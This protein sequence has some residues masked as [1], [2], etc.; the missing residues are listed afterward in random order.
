MAA[1]RTS[2]PGRSNQLASSS[3]GPHR[4][5]PFDLAEHR[6]VGLDAGALVGRRFAVEVRARKK[7]EVVVHGSGCDFVSCIG[8]SPGVPR[9]PSWSASSERPRAILDLTVP[10][11]TPSSLGDLVVVE[12]G[13]VAEHDRGPEVVGQAGDRGVERH[14]IRHR[15]DAALGQAIG[16]LR[17]LAVVAHDVQHRAPAPAAE[18][19]EGG[20]AGDPV[21]PC[22]ER[23][24]AVERA[25]AP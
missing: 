15:V 9:F 4:A 16:G 18:L 17:S 11:G 3:R 10:I 7:G 6:R 25:Q 2:S 1:S 23:R 8:R 21:G 19:V 20:V 5:Q 22:A 14:P 12:V 13:D 24:S